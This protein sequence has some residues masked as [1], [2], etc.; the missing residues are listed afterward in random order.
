MRKST[1]LLAIFLAVL[2]TVSVLPVSAFAANNVI[3]AVDTSDLVMETVFP[4]TS[5]NAYVE[6]PVFYQTIPATVDGVGVDL[7]VTWTCIDAGGYNGKS[8]GK[9][10]NF[11]AEANGYTWDCEV[12]VIKVTVLDAKWASKSKKDGFATASGMP[13]PYVVKGNGNGAND[14]YDATGCNKLLVDRTIPTDYNLYSG[15]HNNVAVSG[16][17]TG[18]LR[19][20]VTDGANILKV[21]GSG[22]GIAHNGDSYVVVNDATIDVVYGGG[23]GNAHVSGTSYI[24]VSGLVDIRKITAGGA[25]SIATVANTVVNVHDLDENA[26]IE[27][28]EVG[29]GTKLTVNL[30]ESAAYLLDSITNWDTSSK[31]TVNINGEGVEDIVDGAVITGIPETMLVGEASTLLPTTFGGLSGF[32]WDGD[33]TSAGTKT[34][35]LTAPEGYF[36]S[37][38]ENGYVKS[39]NYTVIVNNELVEVNDVTIDQGNVN[40]A[41]GK[42]ITLTA[43][44]KPDNANDKTVTWS[45]EDTTIVSVDSATGK[46]T[47]LAEGVA[48]VTATAGSVSDTCTVTVTSA[49]EITDVNTEDLVL[50]TVFPYADRDNATSRWSDVSNNDNEVAEPEFYPTLS[51][52]LEGETEYS[53][54][55]VEWVCEDYDSKTFGTYEF[56]ATPPAGYE[57]A[58]GKAPVI[59]VRVVDGSVA[60]SKSSS[61]VYGFVSGEDLIANLVVKG[62][63]NGRN[64]Y[65]DATGFNRLSPLNNSSGLILVAGVIA[66]S[67]GIAG[68]TAFSGTTTGNTGISVVGV[69]MSDIYGG[70]RSLDHD[71]D[72][73]IDISGKSVFKNLYGGGSAKDGT[74]A[75]VSGTTY[76]TFHDLEIGWSFNSISR[77][78]ASA[79]VIDVDNPEYAL[80]IFSKVTDWTNVTAMIDGKEVTVV[81]ELDIGQTEFTVPHGTALAD[82]NLPTS[83]TV[84]GK[85]VNGFTWEG[86]YIPSRAGTYVLTLTPPEDTFLLVDIYVTVTVEAKVASKIINSVTTQTATLSVDYGTSTEDVIALLPTEFL[87][88]DG[89]L[90]VNAITWEPTGEHKAHVPGEY[91]F[92][93]VL[94]DEDYAYADGVE[95][96]KAVVTVKTPTAQGVIVTEIDLP[97]NYTVF[98]KDTGTVTVRNAAGTASTETRPI[99]F[100]DKLDAVA[101][102]NGVRKEVEIT[103]IEWE[104][105]KV[106]TD[107]KGEYWSYSIKSYDNTAEIAPEIIADTTITVYKTQETYA[108]KSTNLKADGTVIVP[109]VISLSGEEAYSGGFKGYE[110]MAAMDATGFNNLYKDISLTNGCTWYA[111]NSKD[112][113]ADVSLTVGEGASL[114]RIYAGG[115][116]AS[117]TGDSVVT[118]R[119]NSTVLKDVFAGSN[120]HFFVGDSTLNFEEGSTVKG[121]VYASGTGTFDGNV[122]IN[123]EKGVSL[124]GIALGSNEEYYP[125]SVTINVTSDFDL[126]LIEGLETGLIR[127]FVDGV[128]KHYVKEVDFGEFRI[129]VE[130]GAVSDYKDVLPKVKVTT[131]GNKTY[132]VAKTDYTW[133][134][135]NGFDGNKSGEYVFTLKFN[136]N[137]SLLNDAQL[138]NTF[139]VYVKVASADVKTVSEIT[140]AIPQS[141][142][143]PVGTA[144]DDVKI[145]SDISAYTYGVGQTASDAVLEEIRGVKWTSADY[146]PDTVGEYTFTM[147]LPDGYTLLTPVTVT[148]EVLKV[149]HPTITAIRVP[150][151]ETYF[152]K[153]I[154]TEPKFYDVLEADVLYGDSSTDTVTLTGIKWKCNGTYK[155]STVG[156]YEFVIDSSVF[157]GKYEVKDGLLEE[158]KITVHLVDATITYGGNSSHYK[159]ITKN[160]VPM[161]IVSENGST[162]ILDLTGCNK[163]YVAGTLSTTA[164]V[165]AGGDDGVATVDGQTA[166][167]DMASGT[168]QLLA[169]GSFGREFNGNAELS[170]FGTA[171]ITDVVA[172]TVNEAFNGNAHITLDGEAEIGKIIAGSQYRASA[173]AD[174]TIVGSEDAV[175]FNGTVTI[176]IKDTFEGSIGSIVK[177]ADKLIINCPAGFPYTSYVDLTDSGVEVYVDGVRVQ[178]VTDVKAP[179]KTVYNVALGTESIVLPTTLEATVNG[180]QGTINGVTWVCE[181]Y[182]AN[183]AGKYTFTPVIPAQY[184]LSSVD[185]ANISVTVR[186]LTANAGQST[187]TGFAPISAISASLGTAEK[188]I[189]LPATVK[190]TVNGQQ[191]DVEV[192]RWSCANYDGSVYGAE[193]TFT[194]TVSGEYTLG[195]SA[196]TVSVTI[197]NAKITEIYL[198]VTETTFPRGAVE[199]PVFYDTLKVKLDNGVVADISGFEWTVKDY[200]A[201]TLGTYTATIKAAPANCEF[202]SSATIPTIKVTVSKQKYAVATLDAHVYLYGI[203]TVIN[204]DNDGTYLYDIT[205]CNKTDA[206][207]VAGKTIFGGGPAKSGSIASTK[208]EVRGGKVGTIY[209]SSRDNS[210]VAGTSYTYVLGGTVGSIYAG[211]HGGTSEAALSLT[212]NTYVYIENAEVSSRLA[213]AYNGRIENNATVIVKNADVYGIYGGSYA[214]KT[215]MT[216]EGKSIIKLLDGANVQRV[217]G[218]GRASAVNELEIYLSK[219]AI[220][221]NAIN[222][223]AMSAVSGDVEIYYETGFDLSKVYTDEEQVKLYEGHFL[224]DRETFVKD[225]EIKII[226]NAGLIRGDFYVELGTALEDIGLPTTV[227]GEIDGELETVSGITYTPVSYYDGNRIGSYEFELVVPDGYHITNKPM[228]NAGKINVVVTEPAQNDYITAI[229]GEDTG[230]TLANGTAIEN[231]GLPSAYT[232]VLSAGRQKTIPVKN[233][234][235]TDEN[236]RSVTYDRNTAETYVFTPEFDSAYKVLSTVEI[237]THTVKIS[238]YRLYKTG[239]TRYLNGIPADISGVYVTDKNGNYLDTV[240]SMST[241]YGGSI[242]YNVETTDI[243]LNSGTINNLYGGSNTRTVTGDIKITVNGGT[244]TN[245]YAG[246]YKSSAENIKVV[247][248][249]GTITNVYGNN[250]GTIYGLVNYEVNGGKITNF[251]IGSNVANG[252]IQ[253]VAQTEDELL[254]EHTEKDKGP[255][256]VKEGELISAVFVQNGGTIGTL[257]GGGSVANSKVTGSVKMYFNSGTATTICGGGAA[258]SATVMDN[259]YIVIS[260]GF[261]CTDIMANSPGSVY[262]TAYVVVP[263]YFNR[264]SIMGW[265]EDDDVISDDSNIPEDDESDETDDTEVVSN[266]GNVIVSGGYYN[267]EEGIPIKV[268]SG[269]IYARGVPIRVVAETTQNGEDEEDVTTTT[270]LW[271]FDEN[272]DEETETPEIFSY[273]TYV[274]ADRNPVVLTGVWRKLPQAISSSTTIYGGGMNGTVDKYPSTYIEFKGGTLNGVYGG[275]ANN[276]VGAANLILDADE[277]NKISY[278]YAGG[279][280]DANRVTEK[281]YVKVLKGSYSRIVAGGNNITNHGT[282]IDIEGGKVNHVYMAG[283]SSKSV[284]TGTTELNLRNCTVGNIYGGGYG[285]DA[286]TLGPSYINVYENVNITGTIYPKGVGKRADG[287]NSGSV[288]LWAYVT[289]NDPEQV[290]SQFKKIKYTKAQAPFIFVNG[291]ALGEQPEITTAPFET[292]VKRVEVT[293]PEASDTRGNRTM[294]FLNGIP[295]VI[296]GDGNGHTYLYQAKTKD[297]TLDAYQKNEDGTFKY[298][299]N[300]KRISNIVR[301]PVTGQAIK[302]PKL[303]DRDISDDV[304]YG[305][306]N[307][308]SVEDVYIEFHNGGGMYSFYAG[309]RGGNAGYDSEG[310]EVGLIEVRQFDGG[311]FTLTYLGSVSGYDIN[312]D[313]TVNVKTSRNVFLGI[314]GGTRYVGIGGVNG[315]IGSEEKF[316][317]GYYNRAGEVISYTDPD[318]DQVY[319]IT[320]KWEDYNLDIKKEDYAE[321]Y[322][323]TNARFN[324]EDNRD[325][326]ESDYYVDPYD[327]HYTNYCLFGEYATNYIYLGTSGTEYNFEL[328]RVYG[329]G[330][331]RQSAYG[332]KYDAKLDMFVEDY[333]DYNGRY[334]FIADIHLGCTTGAM[335]GDIRHDHEAVAATKVN[336]L[337]IIDSGAVNYGHTYVNLYETDTNHN[338]NNEVYNALKVKSDPRLTVN[339]NFFPRWSHTA[340]WA[341]DIDDN[342][343][344]LAIDE[345]FITG[346][347]DIKDIRTSMIAAEDAARLLNYYYVGSLNEGVTTKNAAQTRG[348]QEVYDASDDLGKFVIRHFEIRHANQEG[349]NRFLVKSPSRFGDGQLITF[350][351]GETMLIDNGQSEPD[352]LIANIK[353]VLE[354]LEQQGIGDGKTLDYVMITHYHG[355]HHTNT[356][357]IVRAFDIKTMIM[358]PFI[359]NGVDPNYMSVV[360]AKS[361]QYVAEGKEPIKIIR[362]VR[363]DKL[364]IGEGE[365][366]VEMLVVNPGDNSRRNFSLAEGLRRCENG[367][368]GGFANAYSIGCKFTF[369]GQVYFTAGDIKAD[370]EQSILRTYGKDFVKCDV[371]KFSH[372]AHANANIWAFVNAANPD[373]AIQ[374]T[375]VLPYIN[376]IVPKY[377]ANNNTGGYRESVYSTGIQGNIK[378]TMDGEKVTSVTQFQDYAYQRNTDEYKNLETSYNVLLDRVADTIDSLTVVADNA[379]APYG[380]AYIWKSHANYIDGQFEELSKRF[381]SNTM[382]IDML[383]DYTEM[384]LDLEDFIDD[385]TMYGGSDTTPDVEVPGTPETDVG[386]NDTTTPGTQ[387]GIIGD[388]G[389]G[390]AGAGIGGG[391]GGAAPGGA[392]VG[393]VG[394]SVDDGE[395][396]DP[397]TPDDNR[398]FID[399]AETDWFNKVVNYVADNNYFQGVSENEFDP[400]GKMT[401]AMLVTVIGRIAKADVSQAKS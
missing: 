195:V 363:G 14:I 152:T 217:Y 324:G 75:K 18:T 162:T 391:A 287:V 171:K 347:T 160:V 398:R 369:K 275:G 277:G 45:T 234:K 196:P 87:A 89:T 376:A 351:N 64:E 120:R 100:Y 39:K 117:V 121:K 91:T 7:P 99:K 216:V 348:Y 250:G 377:C 73:Y 116:D 382:S 340:A 29:Y 304:L 207:N 311:A 290:S 16:G 20:E 161:Y 393:P 74:S 309:C 298:D 288:M 186:V 103:G 157:D 168:I 115:Y 61:A 79:M 224:E 368:A 364:I 145:L 9:V 97:V 254:A 183:T 336:P 291:V 308:K 233:W 358:P 52:L 213:S 247:I 139:V 205:G 8:T 60:D 37:D 374:T 181:N 284:T 322:E 385:A 220:L 316:L 36:I 209:G 386:G 173:K 323:S 12:P 294:V 330:Y 265:N 389:G 221:G 341:L 137:Y 229:S 202:A 282:R 297:G 50:E 122:T 302:G 134:A 396:T 397:V 130:N 335:Y 264:Y 223:T 154:V 400:D 328:N 135:V 68:K 123:V 270:R 267:D 153:G 212:K 66:D 239:N 105:V 379:T 31:I 238:E 255:I 271:Y 85:V 394:P 13:V 289:L 38:T 337:G 360:Y 299:E 312:G 266:S 141:V 2:M 242:M 384:M 262:G 345:G 349:L 353:Y 366:E 86:E 23:M 111:G 175:A 321:Y 210:R 53:D 251:Y 240:N 80:E 200:N 378:V 338:M 272:Y 83:F 370:A 184:D 279:H 310:N 276:T 201:D 280:L 113:V 95:A 48:T 129:E 44:V 108:N 24:D 114:T 51:V 318:D 293:A 320:G 1:R 258:V 352:T 167:A 6:S 230:Y 94:T 198:P 149:E 381:Y 326:L 361:E 219:N 63:E 176:T 373:V 390:D 126:S 343:K 346:V 46:V 62:N 54:L 151:T 21:N 263:D 350:P 42:E 392:I 125:D 22:H 365:N 33:D 147:V 204:G 55:A 327:D 283:Y 193:Y 244:V 77:G 143:V 163:I 333:N 197:T 194:A 383:E 278:I 236:G 227:E 305:G 356:A 3:S 49:I 102:E 259:V 231:V 155:S 98:T 401:R 11:E 261:S 104:G 387:G 92:V 260:D 109:A 81:S 128:E 375:V 371:M 274:D 306:A 252:N 28:I 211:G 399:V 191:V 148:V 88:N 178:Y 4:Y 314:G 179:S 138:N 82:V 388:I 215:I 132:E 301:D 58:D 190:A 131:I 268:M 307:A 84:G 199:T 140:T 119:K 206:A 245:I 281:I 127:V 19:I 319:E 354:Q 180:A 232:V 248:N 43:T 285:K 56:V 362:P 372:H 300:G 317:E 101:Y 10:Y 185:M 136:E 273:E 174:S 331:F 228:K 164:R 67:K 166:R 303:V 241:V 17:S 214:T 144:A 41:E 76:V 110:G 208:I 332:L 218:S 188:D 35:T 133:T 189:A 313:Q 118:L 30:D 158:T 57:F 112:V 169:G 65:Y 249:N 70:N 226:R 96:F 286:K 172:G 170:I 26:N 334:G 315:T 380:T 225:R 69:N 32:T 269:K 156:N 325:F 235:V 243:T 367:E 256:V 165:L 339:L 182:D 106:S 357:P 355:D 72:A 187:I 5:G 177:A 359:P 222:P 395:T 344:Q 150:V 342:L 71:G 295:T 146:N 253:G 296:A 142:T 15:L 159:T 40:L 192:D 90:T 107:S 257:Y 25:Q 203:P 237:P 47:A 246:S 124:G 34:F 329:N 78:T 292:A 93:S 27:A 59:T